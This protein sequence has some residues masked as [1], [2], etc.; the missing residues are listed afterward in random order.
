M[1][2][3]IYKKERKSI[4][5]QKSNQLQDTNIQQDTHVNKSPN[6]ERSD[7][8]MLIEIN[9][10][11]KTS[12]SID[13]KTQ[14]KNLF[15]KAGNDICPH[16]EVK[17]DF[18]ASRARTCPSC[19]KHMVVRQGLFLTDDQASLLQ[20]EIDLHMNR[21]ILSQNFERYLKSAQDSRISKNITRY[22]RDL[23]ESFRFAAQIADRRD[24]KGFSF[25]DKAWKYYNSA[26]M[27]A[28]KDL[29]KGLDQYSELPEISF[30]MT[31]MLNEQ[32]NFS[33]SSKI[34]KQSLRYACMTIAESC[35]FGTTV[36][37]TSELYELAKK[38]ISDLKIDEKEFI[39]ISDSASITY[40]LNGDLLNVYKQKTKELFEYQLI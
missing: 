36:F 29:G 37:F 4:L 1:F 19:G 15:P 3:N 5:N 22:Y 13:Y 30:E 39:E 38:I 27:S 35:K 18:S 9:K 23:A 20:K 25:W 8:N 32:G 31:R 33:K 28:M 16:C 26:R 6:T 40:K 24:E 17:F 2:L 21:D 7:F 10:I 11:N 34:K 14:V 12:N